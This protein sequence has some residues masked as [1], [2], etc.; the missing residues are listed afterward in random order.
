MQSQL[1][2]WFKY[3]ILNLLIPTTHA[4]LLLEIFGILMLNEWW[5]LSLN[6]THNYLSKCWLEFQMEG[7]W[8]FFSYFEVR[9]CWQSPLSLVSTHSSCVSI[10]CPSAVLT[11]DPTRAWVKSWISL[12]A[13]NFRNLPHLGVIRR[14]V[15]DTIQD[16][17]CELGM[18]PRM[19]LYEIIIFPLNQVVVRPTKI[20]KDLCKSST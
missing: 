4:K 16:F 13:D 20:I 9:K 18:K 7:A 17:L 2:L 19:Q 15:A 14:Y 10:I 8:W 12:W 5:S 11:W 3:V 6:S 1:N